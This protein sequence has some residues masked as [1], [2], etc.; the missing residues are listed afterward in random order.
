MS[1]AMPLTNPCVCGMRCAAWIASIMTAQPAM[2]MIVPKPKL[3][4]KSTAVRMAAA[5]AI[6][7]AV[8]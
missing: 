4:P 8:P 5:P 6:A 2:L 7:D 1:M 3:S